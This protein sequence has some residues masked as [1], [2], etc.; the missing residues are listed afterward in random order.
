MLNLVYD[1]CMRTLFITALLTACAS[2][3]EPVKAGGSAPATVECD[4]DASPSLIIGQGTGS[5]FTALEEGQ[6]VG[7]DV[8]PQ[9]GYGV[10][11]RAKTTGLSTDGTVDVLLETA[12]NDVESGSFVNEGTNLYCQ[13]DGTGLLWGVV[14]GFDPD[15]FP[16]PDDL[17]ALDGNEALLIV[18]ATDEDGNIASGE[19][20]VTIEV[21]G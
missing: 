3:K 15:T 20:M 18:E 8:A 7:L 17:I 19:V 9:G 5:E 1:M 12:I 16:T 2:E 14:V 10:S 4:P 21:G 11:V 6:S 13:E